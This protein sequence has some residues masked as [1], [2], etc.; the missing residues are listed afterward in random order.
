MEL[1][2]V[3]DRFDFRIFWFIGADTAAHHVFDPFAFLRVVFLMSSHPRNCSADSEVKD[4]A[5]DLVD[6]LRSIVV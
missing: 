5:W 3:P 2:N 1:R 6:L 4:G